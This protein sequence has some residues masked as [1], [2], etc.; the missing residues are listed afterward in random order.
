MYLYTN[1][2]NFMEKYCFKGDCK[3]N[4]EF[5]PSSYAREIYFF[6]IKIKLLNTRIISFHYITQYVFIY[7]WVKFHEK[8]N[9]L[10][11]WF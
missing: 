11:G 5:L 2:Q 8:K 4:V 6:E 3:Q 1:V 9:V 7:Y 10:R